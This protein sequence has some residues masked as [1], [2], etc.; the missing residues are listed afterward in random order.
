MEH[1]NN[2]ISLKEALHKLK[3]AA[4]A[5]NHRRMLILQ[6]TSDPATLM[7]AIVED[8][9]GFSEN[10]VLVSQTI[11]AYGHDSSNPGSRGT[12]NDSLTQLA[13]VSKTRG[14]TFTDPGNARAILLGTTRSMIVCDLSLDPNPDLL[15]V[16]TGTIKGG[17]LLILLTPPFD[18]W[19]EEAVLY[20]QRLA[21]PPF[22]QEQTGHR[23]MDRLIQEVQ[24]GDG[25]L[26][27]LL[28]T[29]EPRGQTDPIKEQSTEE[30]A[31]PITNTIHRSANELMIKILSGADALSL[32]DNSASEAPYHTNG[33]ST[34]ATTSTTASSSLITP[35]DKDLT[36]MERKAIEACLTTDQAETVRRLI[37][38]AQ[39]PGP[40]IMIIEADRGR[41]K[42]GA[43]G[44]GAGVLLHRTSP[45]NLSL[46]PKR[47][48][49]K[50]SQQQVHGAE[51]I[52]QCSHAEGQ[53]MELDN[54]AQQAS[55]RFMDIVVTSSTPGGT[56]P[57][58]ALAKMTAGMPLDHGSDSAPP[59]QANWGDCILLPHGGRLRLLPPHEAA[60]TT[61]DMLMVDEAATIQ[62]QILEMLMNRAPKTVFATTIHGYEGTGMG[63]SVRFMDRL[64]QASIP[65]TQV[66]MEH[67]IR[68]AANDPVERWATQVLMLD[69]THDDKS[70]NKDQH[71][72][73]SQ[74]PGVTATDRV[75]SSLP[76]DISPMQANHALAHYL[77]PDKEALV[78]NEH[79]LRAIFGLLLLAHYRT[80]P[81]DLSII[82]DSPAVEVRGLVQGEQV[83]AAALID[84]EGNLPL[85]IAN[86]SHYGTSARL[87]GNLLPETLISHMRLGPSVGA[88]K[89]LRIVRLAVHPR[90]RRQGLGTMLV[91]HIC[92]EKMEYRGEADYLGIAFGATPEL[93]AFWQKKCGFLPVRLGTRRGTTS[94]EKSVIMLRPVTSAGEQLVTHARERFNSIIMDQL[95]DHLR[96]LNPATVLI[97]VSGTEN[98]SRISVPH[99]PL[100]LD[101]W[102]WDSLAALCTGAQNH[103][104]LVSPMH[105]L[106]AYWL[107]DPA[108]P[109]PANVI[110]TGD[111]ELLIAKALQGRSWRETT[112]TSPPRSIPETMRQYRYVMEQ[113]LLAYGP[114]AALKMLDSYQSARQREGTRGK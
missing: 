28:S 2:L 88:L 3:L 87:R 67:P 80:R 106:A 83:V 114:P 91:D 19:W 44:L 81:S 66:H 10:G 76:N 61:C 8:L 4:E 89:A 29:C 36:A 33:D 55:I 63:F 42:S 71:H 41:G 18:A 51:K 47:G 82:M 68:W 101:D 111:K 20:R 112:S 17:G 54:Q 11:E 21:P 75:K 60:V 48:H 65:L 46:P 103:D 58:L 77:A 98:R 1:H 92:N 30:G 62:V 49:N 37:Y 78:K 96:D 25:I 109:H 85:H 64:R 113:L 9:P 31:R 94:G 104:A 40:A 5:S 93:C 22:T 13:Q 105:K 39:S 6:S 107:L 23:F 32:P 59:K 57:L 7:G 12:L 97:T 15:G 34:T 53:A 90:F 95:R 14:I 45:P 108:P 70:Y 73:T 43:L 35:A 38:M 72:D 50:A 16:L 84:K 86:T 56:G 79:T 27:C 69:A 52:A 110:S 100:S 99:P 26:N 74:G 102:E 24:A